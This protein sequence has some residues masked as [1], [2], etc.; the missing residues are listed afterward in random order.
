MVGEAVDGDVEPAQA[1]DAGDRAD[2]QVR[3]LEQ[4]ALLDVQLEIGVDAAAVADG[5]GEPID[6]PANQADAF[7]E[8]AARAGDAS[9]SAGFSAP[10]GELAAD[11]AALFVLPDRRPRAD[12]AA[13]P[14]PRAGVRATSIAPKVPTGPSKLPP[15]VTEST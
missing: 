3:S 9:R 1:D 2:A 5:L 12:A 11:G 10:I 8:G 14:G 4:A 7:A 6:R 15:S 13:A